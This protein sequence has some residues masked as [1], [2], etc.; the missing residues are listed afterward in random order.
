MQTKR[1]LISAVAAL[2]LFFIGL[3]SSS[4]ASAAG[5]SPASAGHDQT[6]ISGKSS[7]AQVYWRGGG[8]RGAGWGG[9]WRGGGW[10]GAGWR[11]GWGWPVGAGLV[12][13][14]LGYGYPGWGG[15]GYGGCGGW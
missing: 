8:W 6:A 12:G 13:L 3:L 11:G 10:R 5:I 4:P 7:V 1:F 14:G 2:G 9:G 15:Y